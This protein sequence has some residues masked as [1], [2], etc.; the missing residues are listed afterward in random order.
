MSKADGR[1]EVNIGGRKSWELSRRRRDVAKIWAR[2]GAKV[3]EAVG[4][5][6]CD[7]RCRY[8]GLKRKEEGEYCRLRN[9]GD[10]HSV[11]DKRVR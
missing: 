2:T 7:G 1:N 11:Q 9:R 3:F 8:M 6:P 4:R 5:Q 10:E